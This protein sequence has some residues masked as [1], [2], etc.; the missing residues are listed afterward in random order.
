MKTL[1]K[2]AIGGFILLGVIAI[3]WW[4]LFIRPGQAQ[5][6]AADARAGAAVATARVGSAA[7]AVNAVD[8]N[9]AVDAEIDKIGRTNSE[10]I[11]KAPDA[12]VSVPGVSGALRRGLC[13]RAS[14]RDT[15]E[16]MQHA[17][18]AGGVEPDAARALPGRR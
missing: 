14:Y 2:N 17:R 9:A 10:A 7:V 15:A 6:E 16:C 3:L 8:D 13:G 18:T 12:G 11:S 5:R 4:V 1:S